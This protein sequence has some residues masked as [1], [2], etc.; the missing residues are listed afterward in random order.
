MSLFYLYHPTSQEIWQPSPRLG[1]KLSH[2]LCSARCSPSVWA[3]A[4]EVPLLQSSGTVHDAC[5]WQ[6]P[7]R[8]GATRPAVTEPRSWNVLGSHSASFNGWLL[9]A[10][11]VMKEGPV[12]PTREMGRRNCSEV[13]MTIPSFQKSLI[14]N[15]MSHTVSLGNT[16][17]LTIWCFL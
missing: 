2:A 7:A 14:K 4:G 16:T 10:L 8:C 11:H 1:T 3:A 17:S 13:I 6:L 5:C 15:L 12:L 9:K